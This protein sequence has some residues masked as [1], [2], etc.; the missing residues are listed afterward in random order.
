LFPVSVDP[1]LSPGTG[2]VQLTGL[3]ISVGPI[4]LLPVVLTIRAAVARF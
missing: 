4:F 1:T 2:A 3:A